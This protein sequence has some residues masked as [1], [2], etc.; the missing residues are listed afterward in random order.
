MPQFTKIL[1]PVDT[2]K[3]KLRSEGR[4]FM[5]TVRRNDG[6]DAEKQFVT[7]GQG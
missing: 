6:D 5:T 1:C 3:V 4:S 2:L 7:L